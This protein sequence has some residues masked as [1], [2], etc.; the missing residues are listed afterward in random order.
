MN[1]A[2]SIYPRQ[3]GLSLAKRVA[4]HLFIRPLKL[5]FVRWVWDR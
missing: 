1:P 4:T 2:G 3:L 5:T